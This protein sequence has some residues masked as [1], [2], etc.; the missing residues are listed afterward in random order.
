MLK[1]QCHTKTKM[2]N[3]ISQQYKSIT[4]QISKY[5]GQG[6]KQSALDTISFLKDEACKEEDLINIKRTE[7]KNKT[8]FIRR[9]F[10][11]FD[12]ESNREISQKKKLFLNYQIPKNS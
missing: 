4:Q 12:R 11:D 2:E 1:V 8:T 9:L 5:S 6:I 3:Q 7:W 10:N